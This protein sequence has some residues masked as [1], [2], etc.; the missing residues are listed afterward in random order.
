MTHRWEKF[1]ALLRGVNGSVSSLHS[2]S[3]I[4]GRRGDER[5]GSKSADNEGVDRRQRWSSAVGVAVETTGPREH[6][7][8]VGES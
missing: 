2:R 4:G 1:A 3:A 8:A 5:A 6:P 7:R